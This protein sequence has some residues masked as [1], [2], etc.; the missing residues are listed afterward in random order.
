MQT[1]IPYEYNIFRILYIMLHI[2]YTF[3]IFNMTYYVLL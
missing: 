2:K 3:T 1:I